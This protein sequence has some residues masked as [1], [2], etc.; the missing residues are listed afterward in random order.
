[1]NFLAE[2]VSI[3][4]ICADKDCEVVFMPTRH[5]QK[6]CSKDC[7]KR[8]TNAKIMAQYYEKKDRKAGK[9]RMCRSCKVTPLSRYNEGDTCQSCVLAER[10]ANRTQLLSLVG[11]A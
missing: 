2:E 3:I 6:Y 7:C 1:M 11:M 8:T 4:K 5:N 9:K 10:S